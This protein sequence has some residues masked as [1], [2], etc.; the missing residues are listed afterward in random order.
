MKERGKKP[1]TKRL[2]GRKYTDGKK[3]PRPESGKASRFLTPVRFADIGSAKII[4]N[5]Y[6][7]G[8]RGGMEFLIIAT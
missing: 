1:A 8:W 4:T 2:T 3:N 5:R 6:P 7:D